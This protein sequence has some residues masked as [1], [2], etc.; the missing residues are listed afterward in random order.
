MRVLRSKRGSIRLG[1]EVHADGG[2]EQIVP[3]TMYPRTL[4]RYAAITVGCIRPRLLDA[5]GRAARTIARAI[6]PG[7]AGMQH[8]EESLHL[9]YRIWGLI[10]G[11]K[12]LL[13]E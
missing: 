1:N 7:H 3:S 8:F 11:L 4:E 10:W 5:V 2:H 6:V 12:R 9:L 13:V